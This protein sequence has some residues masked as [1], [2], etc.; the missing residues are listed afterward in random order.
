MSNV[1]LLMLGINL[2]IHG[3]RY[4]IETVVLLHCS[5]CDNVFFDVVFPTPLGFKFFKHGEDPVG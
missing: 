4:T 3:G 5:L 1:V 2:K